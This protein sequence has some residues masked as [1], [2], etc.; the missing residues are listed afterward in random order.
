MG[1]G[2]DAEVVEAA[3]AGHTDAMAE[4]YDRYGDRIYGFCL[5]LTRDPERAAD[6]T[7]DTF[8]RAVQSLGQLRDPTRLRSWLFAIARNQVMGSA[9]S[10]GR[11]LASGDPLEVEEI[12]EGALESPVAADPVGRVIQDDMVRL[13][14][15][16]AAGLDERDRLL[17]E[18]NLRQGLEGAE[19]AEAMGVEPGHGYVMFAR[20]RERIERSLGAL[21]VARLGREDCTDLA[22]LLT[23]WD[24]RFSVRLRKRVVRHVDS[25]DTCSRSRSSLVAPAAL[26]ASVPF[27]PSP[28]DLRDRILGRMVLAS[29]NTPIGPPTARPDIG[30]ASAP[31]R[32]DRTGERAAPPRPG[33]WGGVALP[34]EAPGPPP[35]SPPTGEDANRRRRGLWI[36]G[37]AVA[38]ILLGV[39]VLST[40]RPRKA[41]VLASDQPTTT[42][43]PTTTAP[44]GSTAVLPSSTTEG[45]SVPAPSSSAGAGTD[46][47]SSST[48]AS[49]GPT[50]A[51]VSPTS[52][53]PAPTAS[54]SPPAGVTT[55]ADPATTTTRVTTTAPVPPSSTTTSESSTTSTTTTTT[56][57]APPTTTVPSS[58]TTT[59]TTTS[60]TTTSPSSTTTSEVSGPRLRV[61]PGTV[62]LQS[63]S[64]GFRITNE[65]PGP[66][67]WGISS[68]DPGLEFSQSSGLLGEGSTV[69][70]T[71]FAPALNGPTVF[72]VTGGVQNV[73]VTVVPEPPPESSTTTTT[74]PIIVVPPTFGFPTT[75][76]VF[77]TPTLGTPPGP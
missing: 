77:T 21:L 27:I 41:V 18:L 38:L 36:S 62:T 63:V 7:Q 8:V 71:V 67:D 48:S 24:G 50:A 16:A 26:F 31:N 56:T 42:V 37:A 9:R 5:S 14:W 20:M 39:L 32:L 23:G 11:M 53:A 76:L 60:S 35:P 12:G 19:L 65:G 2:A 59:S 55:T 64:G 33:P 54:T 66:A 43:A 49:P 58:S 44:G 15:D 13:V 34:V 1:Y 3:R 52:G 70:V 61:F 4:I 75:T 22:A 29:A 69:S 28:V 6:A 51:A 68:P 17:L 57:T 74:T 73:T 72:T 45:T 47:T 30:R 25:C 40:R 10:E 46:S